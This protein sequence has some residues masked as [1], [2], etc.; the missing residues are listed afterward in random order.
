MTQISQDQFN[1]VAAFVL[2]TQ[3]DQIPDQTLE[4]AQHLLLDTLGVA[5]AASRL[6]AGQIA[7]DFTAD[8]HAPGANGPRAHILFD[9]RIASPT[10]A[11]FA[12]AAQTDNLDAH[13]GYNLTK[14]HIGVA[15]VPALCAFGEGLSSLSGREALASLVIAYEIAGRAGRALHDT[16]SDYH[17][18]GAWNAIGVAA[19]GARLRSLS[20]GQLREAMGIAEYH[21]PRSQMMREIDNPTMLHDGSSWGTLAGM[22]AVFMAERGFTG[23]PAITVEAEDIATYW[24]DLGAHWLTDEQYVKPYPIC[25]WA[26]APIDGAD[27]LRRRHNLDHRQIERVEVRTFHESARL[28]A[29]MPQQP[30]IAQYSL[31]FA[32]ASMLVNGMVGVDQ[33]TGDGLRDEDVAR[34]VSVTHVSEHDLYN[35]RFPEGRW[36]DLSLV[37]SDGQ[38]LESGPLNARGGPGDQLPNSEVIGK[39]HAYAD[40]VLGEGR[41]SALKDAILALGTDGADF[42]DVLRIAIDP[43]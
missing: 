43:A 15:V 2:D 23:A 17:T 1:R 7:R 38:R 33:I 22:S 24:K 5:I 14:G 34:L 39:Y 31:A 26:H 11:G 6:E 8:H 9:G 35:K 36:A 37:L 32:V 41:A 10:G 27:I 19:L 3:P 28:F 21:G 18:S 20:S 29:G 40:P 42:A 4:K 30:S 12:L 13:D 16:V 25:R